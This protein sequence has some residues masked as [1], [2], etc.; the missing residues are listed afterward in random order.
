MRQRGPRAAAAMLAGAAPAAGA[1]AL[2]ERYELPLPLG[3]VVAGACAA[4]L[5]TFVLAAFFARAGAGAGE[6]REQ[7]AVSL[8]K[9]AVLLLR[10]LSVLLFAVTI[11]AALW[12]TQDPL[13]NLA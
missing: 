3:Y 8:P 2:A 6:E 12:G 11:A 1:H 9:A 7:R 4:V 10:A 13:M 5:L